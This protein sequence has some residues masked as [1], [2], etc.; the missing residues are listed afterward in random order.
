MSGFYVPTSRFPAFIGCL[1]AALILSLPMSSMAQEESVPVNGG[2]ITIGGGV[3]FGL[4]FPLAGAIC[5]LVE[6][7][8]QDSFDCDV[9]SMS[10]SEEAIAALQ[11]A[12]VDMAIVQSDWLAHAVAGTSRFQKAGPSGDLRAVAALHSEGLVL[13]VRTDQGLRSAGQLED[14][15]VSVG[16]SQSYRALLTTRLLAGA[17]LS[18]SDLAQMTNETVADGIAGLCRGETDAV[19]AVSATPASVASLAPRGCSVTY[20]AISEDVAAEASAGMPG[21]RPVALPVTRAGEG[22]VSKLSSFGLTAVLTTSANADP[23]KVEIVARALLS[24]A[25]EIS[26]MHPALSAISSGGLQDTDAFAPRH[27]IVDDLFQ[28]RLD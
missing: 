22:G 13:I 27:S 28:G 17:G 6:D 2:S 26:A 4:Y 5:G 15:R 21:I 11:R 10:D 8:E 25:D 3:P 7:L 23:A 24:G 19:A 1:I 18:S 14:M 12:R 16:P 20:L 9:A